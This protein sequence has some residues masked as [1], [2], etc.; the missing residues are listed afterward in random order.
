MFFLGIEDLDF[1]FGLKSFMAVL[2]AATKKNSNRCQGS[3]QLKCTLNV[4]SRSFSFPVEHFLPLKL[5]LLVRFTSQ[6]VSLKVSTQLVV[7]FD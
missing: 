1:R 3:V 7:R 4:D 2:H 5:P 6:S